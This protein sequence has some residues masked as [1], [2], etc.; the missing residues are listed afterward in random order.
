M[1]GINLVKKSLIGILLIIFLLSIICFECAPPTKSSSG[2]S[3]DDDNTDIIIGDDTSRILPLKIGNTW[4]YTHITSAGS[5]TETLNV[6]SVTNIGGVDV[7][8]GD[9]T[10]GTSSTYEYH[11]NH[12]GDGLYFYGDGGI[13]IISPCLFLQYPCSVG[14][15]WIY[16]RWGGTYTVQSISTIVTVDA[17]SFEC[18]VYYYRRDTATGLTEHFEYWAPGIGMIKNNVYKDHDLIDSI[19]LVSYSIL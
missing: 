6:T 3:I 15:S 17:G 2:S 13:G 10:S 11:G 9:S 8:R 5:F 16:D 19:G 4:I 12:V 1:R 18:I 14:D 7:Y